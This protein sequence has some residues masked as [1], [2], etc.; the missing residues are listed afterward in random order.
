VLKVVAGRLMAVSGGGR[1]FRYGGEEFTVVFPGKTAKDA[2][3]HLEKLRKSI[4]EY[5]MALRSDER[6]RM[7][8]KGR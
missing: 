7:M 8:P 6:P 3:P 1:S 2:A 4:E 5:K